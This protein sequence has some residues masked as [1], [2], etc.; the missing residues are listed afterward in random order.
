MNIMGWLNQTRDAY[1]FLSLTED[2]LLVEL[3]EVEAV[4]CLTGFRVDGL[5]EFADSLDDLGQHCLIWV[6]FWRV[7]G[8]SLEKKRIPGETRCRLRYVA[9]KLKLP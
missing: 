3:K 7:L 6:V 1:N 8:H 2:K 9:V 4:L 5:Q